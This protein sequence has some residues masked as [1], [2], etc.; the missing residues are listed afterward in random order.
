MRLP[1]G[2]FGLGLERVA[3]GV[4][5]LDGGGELFVGEGLGVSLLPLVGGVC[6]LAQG[7]DISLGK[8]I[9]DA[10]LGWEASERLIYDLAEL[11][12]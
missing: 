7:R 11:N 3:V 6:E 8:S 10:C 2:G 12:Y 5:G 4:G 9:T 1:C